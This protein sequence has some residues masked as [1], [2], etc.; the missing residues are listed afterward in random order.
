VNLAFATPHDVGLHHGRAVVAIGWNGAEVNHG[1]HAAHGA[2]HRREVAQVAHMLVVDR[3]TIGPCVETAQA[4][5]LP[6]QYAGQMTTDAPF[7][8]GD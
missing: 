5:A 8:T 6:V 4:A 1:I 7:A 3:P 2:A